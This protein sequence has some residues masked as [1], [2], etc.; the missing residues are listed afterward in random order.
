MDGNSGKSKG[1]PSNRVKLEGNWE[2]RAAE[3]L[4]AGP[5][6]PKKKAAKKARKKK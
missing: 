1:W 3:F 4:K 5:M 6:S 2:D